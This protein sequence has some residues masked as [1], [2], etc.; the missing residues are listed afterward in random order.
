MIKEKEWVLHQGSLY[1]ELRRGEADSAEAVIT[2]LSGMVN[3]LCIPETLE[4]AVVTGIAKKAFL[5]KKQLRRVSL[6]STIREL[7]DW[8]FAYCSRLEEVVLPER[9]LVLGKAPFLDCVSLRKLRIKPV[10]ERRAADMAVIQNGMDREAQHKNEVPELLA[11]AVTIFDAY[12]LLDPM[13]V[14]DREWLVKWDARLV[15]YL[16]TDDQEGYSRQVLCGEED[17]GSTDLGAFL[18]NKRKGKVRMCYVR[19]LNSVGLSEELRMELSQYLLEHTAHSYTEDKI[20]EISRGKSGRPEVGFPGEEAWEVVLKEHGEERR[21]YELFA[22]LGCL[23]EDNFD[24]IME[25]IGEEHAEMKAYFLK[26]KE[27]Q[28]GYADFFDSLS[29]D[30]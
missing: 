20:A 15:T 28:I 1:Y 19:L 17:Y 10:G 12:Y 7:G 9:T 11:A 18:N 6:P 8:A 13:Q 5:S 14:G 3:E 21:Y 22:T 25:D 16:H 27:E 24:R 26:Y 23:T 30:L 2:R 4:G 29:L